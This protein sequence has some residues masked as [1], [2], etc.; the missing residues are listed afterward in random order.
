M[1]I[2]NNSKINQLLKQWPSGGVYLS[3]WLSSND[4][5]NQLISRY[6]KSN[7]IKSIG[8][9]AYIRSGDTI[10]IE[11]GIHALQK[12]ANSSIHIGGKSSLAMLG[13]SHYLELGKRQVTLFG[14]STEKLP[15]WFT[16]YQWDAQ[17]N[18]YS[19]SFLPADLG[20]TESPS[21]AFTI[22]ISS[23]PRALMECLYLAPNKQDLIE[24]YE[25][26]EG[27]NNMRP[28]LVQKLLEVCTSIKVKRLFLYMAEQ[29][30]HAWF[31]HINL[32]TIDLG[33]GK[34]EI[35]KN[36]IYIAKYQITVPKEF[37]LYEKL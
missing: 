7:W 28:N 9:G 25:L 13:K 11:G 26:M 37:A 3:A 23:A 4:Y 36:G 21:K 34:R 33:S 18:Y 16:D 17:V 10:T 24:C 27:L 29:A 12:Q 5:S 2:D 14:S 8:K 1:S 30:N 35:V 22:L 15:S 32:S 6:K 31:S 20:L 19:S